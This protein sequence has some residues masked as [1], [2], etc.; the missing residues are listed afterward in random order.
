MSLQHQQFL[1]TQI[2]WFFFFQIFFFFFSV[3]VVFGFLGDNPAA[4]HSKKPPKHTFLLSRTTLQVKRW[5]GCC[6]RCGS[7]RQGHG[8]GRSSVQVAHRRGFGCHLVLVP[9][10]WLLCTV[11][12]RALQPGCAETPRSWCLV[13]ILRLKIKYTYLMLYGL[14]SLITPPLILDT[15]H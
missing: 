9:E 3:H 1:F 13:N 11:P 5:L 10:L 12:V 8:D 4:S 15:D 2:Q 14:S 7:S 6:S